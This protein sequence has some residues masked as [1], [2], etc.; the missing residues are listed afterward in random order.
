MVFVP[1][2]GSVPTIHI[3]YHMGEHYNS[4]RRFDDPGFRPAISGDFV[5]GHELE[6][7]KQIKNGENI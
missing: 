3:S 6:K 7:V 2:I 5:V 4:V 1:P